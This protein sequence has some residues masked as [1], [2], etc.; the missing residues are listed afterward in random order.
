[1]ESMG[2]REGKEDK[3]WSAKGG[4]KERGTHSVGWMDLDGVWDGKAVVL[5]K[6]YGANVDMRS[7]GGGERRR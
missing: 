7:R 3:G 6:N 5:V 2:G 1:M 4:G